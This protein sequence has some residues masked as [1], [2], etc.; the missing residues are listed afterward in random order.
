MSAFGAMSMGLSSF[1]VF[2]PSEKPRGWTTY[3]NRI[4]KF[5][6]IGIKSAMFLKKLGLGP[7]QNSVSVQA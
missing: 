6:R 5:K 2:Y 7:N 3:F 1:S 4:G